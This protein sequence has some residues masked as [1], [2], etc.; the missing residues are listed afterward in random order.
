[1]VVMI[2]FAP[3][4]TSFLILPLL[5]SLSSLI[6]VS[7]VY[8]FPRMPSDWTTGASRYFPPPDP[9]IEASPPFFCFSFFSPFFSK[10]ISPPGS[11]FVNFVQPKRE[12]TASSGSFLVSS[13][14]RVPFFLQ[15]P[16]QKLR[17]IKGARSS[18]PPD[19][20]FFLPQCC[21]MVFFFLVCF[22][23]EPS[24]SLF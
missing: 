10:F 22:S 14:F 21:F 8:V 15:P 18:D 7:R 2:S 13:F 5:Y 19:N 20:P 3:F 11:R 16:P 23:E 24:P 17:R 1:L 4:V 12:I 6:L 9:K